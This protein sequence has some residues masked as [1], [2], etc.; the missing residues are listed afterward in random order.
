MKRNRVR[1]FFHD[2]GYG[3]FIHTSAAGEPLDACLL[4][5]LGDPFAPL[6]AQ[7]S[8][9]I[10]VFRIAVMTARGRTEQHDGRPTVQEMAQMRHEAFAADMKRRPFEQSLENGEGRPASQINGSRK[11]TVLFTA[12][13]NDIH[14]RI[15]LF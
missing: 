5:V 7:R 1:Y 10:T 4:P 6:R 3:Y 14:M 11:V 13:K 2:M 15:L 12:E 8:A 9:D